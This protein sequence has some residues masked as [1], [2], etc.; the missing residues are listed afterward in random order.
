MANRDIIQGDAP[1]GSVVMR[2]ALS[3]EQNICRIIVALSKNRVT[4][5][6]IHKVSHVIHQNTV[7][8]WRRRPNHSDRR[9]R[10]SSVIFRAAIDVAGN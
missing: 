2:N 10:M 4:V 9:I 7:Y 1:C 5:I 6:L 3:C 8:S